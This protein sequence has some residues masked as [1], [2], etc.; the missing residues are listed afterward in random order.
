MAQYT[1]KLSF[2]VLQVTQSLA[3]E[4]VLQDN[5]DYPMQDGGPLA[6]TFNFQAGDEI[7][8]EVIA[9]IPAS[10]DADTFVNEFAVANCTFVS[11]PARM[12]EFL[13]L[14]DQTSACTAINQV[15]ADGKSN[16]AEVKSI[17]PTPQGLRRFA[18]QSLKPLPVVTKEGQWQISGYLSVQLPPLGH[19]PTSG[20]VRHQ[21]YFFDPESSTGDGI[22]FGP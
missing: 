16:W 15:N 4:F 19:V 11:I 2:D 6:G 1:L 20:G 12:I 8:V 9:S 5:S 7:S 17:S 3:Y 18:I 14:F 10:M 21:L 22:G 13:S